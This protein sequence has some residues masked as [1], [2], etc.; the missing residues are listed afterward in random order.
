M[1]TKTKNKPGVKNEHIQT[2]C[3]GCGST[4]EK[5]KEIAVKGLKG[6]KQPFCPPCRTTKGHAY[7]AIPE[8]V[9]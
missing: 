2:T 3:A 4:T 5:S 6:L 9:K 7:L 8:G 1:K